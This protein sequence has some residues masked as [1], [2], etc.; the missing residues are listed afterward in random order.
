MTPDKAIADLVRAGAAVTP[1]LGAVPVPVGVMQRIN[2]N[3]W[4][5][6]AAGG[7]TEFD[8]HVLDGD[9]F[10]RYNGTGVEFTDGKDF[11]GYLTSLEDSFDDDTSLAVAQVAINA[12]RARY[13]QDQELRGFVARQMTRLSA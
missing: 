6:F 4:F 11:A 12:W 2:R 1:T 8:A 9:Q 10:V 13:E 3:R 5:W 7:E